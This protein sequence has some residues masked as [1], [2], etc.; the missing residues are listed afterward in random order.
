MDIAIAGPTMISPPRSLPEFRRRVPDEAVCAYYLAATR[1]PDGFR[2]PECGGSKAWGLSTRSFTWDCA[3][4]GKLTSITARKEFHGSK[5]ALT[6][7]LWAVYLR[8]IHSNGVSELQLRSQFGIASYK[9]A[10]LLFGEIRR[11]IIDPERSS[12]TGVVEIDETTI[13]FRSK[14]DPVT[15]DGECSIRGKMPVIT[16]V[17]IVGNGLG[18]IRMGRI[19]DCAAQKNRA[20]VATNIPSGSALTSEEWSAYP[21]IPEVERDRHV[22]GKM[23]AR[24]VLPQTYHVF[25]N[26]ARRA[27]GVY[28]WPPAKASPILP[29]RVDLPLQLPPH[30]PRRLPLAAQHRRPNNTCPHRI[31]TSLKAAG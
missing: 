17:E 9:T 22:F 18:R 24:L 11:A 14:S 16:A 21:G 28:R 23:D 4:C 10:W 29:R 30:S 31:L 8:A 12:L 1:S 25:S 7:W 19:A 5:L 6:V 3:S 27:L 13:P 2:C 20:F 26:L 15:S